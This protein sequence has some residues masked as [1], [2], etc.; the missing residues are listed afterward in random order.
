M[1]RTKQTARL[2]APVPP[3]DAAHRAAVHEARR[4]AV[5][6][7]AAEDVRGAAEDAA[8]AAADRARARN[9]KQARAW[10]AEKAA[11]AARLDEAHARIR[12][13]CD[14]I[15]TYDEKVEIQG[16]LQRAM[17]ANRTDYPDPR[18]YRVDPVD[19]LIN[20]LVFYGYQ[21]DQWRYRVWHPYDP[22]GIHMNF[23][24][25]DQVNIFHLDPRALRHLHDV[26]V[27]PERNRQEM[28]N[29]FRAADKARRNL[30]WDDE[31]GSWREMMAAAS[32][33]A[34][35]KRM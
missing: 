31:D 25:D 35:R 17:Q 9:L 16:E 2:A 28:R 24:L 3:T 15:V 27:L 1:A 14:E 12:R 6:G 19:L 22:E 11:A 34:K 13:E 5:A 7:A 8:H 10:A 20:T 29:A 26:L 23:A 18:G 21:T 30:G 33:G 32:A 4:P